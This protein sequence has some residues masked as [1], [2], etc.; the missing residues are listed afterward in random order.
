MEIEKICLK[1]TKLCYYKSN[2]PENRYLGRMDQWVKALQMN[3]KVPGSNPTRRSPRF[4]DQPRY[5]A[6]SDRRVET[7]INAVINIG[8]VT[9]SLSNGLKLVM[10]HPKSIQKMI[11]F[12]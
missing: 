12:F 3:K 2:H 10:G 7:L 4:R 6:L 11:A 1:I 5:E 8:L 9:L